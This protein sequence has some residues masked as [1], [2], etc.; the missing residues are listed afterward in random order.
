MVDKLILVRYVS[1]EVGNSM[2]IINNTFG[3]IFVHIPKCGGTSVSMALSDLSQFNDIELGGTAYGQ[4]I[5]RAYHTRFGIGKHSTANEIRSVIGHSLWARYYSF[6]LVRNPYQRAISS[7]CFFKDR[8]QDYQIMTT[9]RNFNEYVQSEEWKGGGP[10]GL[11]L[12][13]RRWLTDASRA[14]LVNE[15]FR[16]ED[17]IADSE[18]LL[19]RLGLNDYRKAQIRFGKANSSGVRVDPNTIEN[20]TIDLLRARYEEDFAL[21]R[22]PTDFPTAGL[23]AAA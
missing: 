4:A 9:F 22:Y 17:I 5:N 6:A 13:Q 10:D 1:A 15:I 16:L 18:P 12:T 3:F 23:S 20:R 8:E 19:R 14:Q 11:N 21:L 2:T 7:Y